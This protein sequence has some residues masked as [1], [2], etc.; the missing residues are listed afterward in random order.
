MNVKKHGIPGIGITGKT[1]ITGKNGPG[2][3]FG[4]LDSF[5]TF[6]GDT[7]LED[8][9]I[10]YEDIDYDITYVQNEERL[11]HIYKVGDLL[12]ITDDNK[13]ILYMVEVTEDLTTC[14]KEY[15][16]NHIKY[17]QPFTVKY[18]KDKNTIN[19]SVNIVHSK[20]NNL[21]L[22]NLFNL[23][24]IYTDAAIS[25]INASN[26]F[27]INKN[28]INLDNIGNSSSLTQNRHEF[29]QIPIVYDSS[30][31]FKKNEYIN[32]G[33]EINQYEYSN[34]EDVDS[35]VNNTLI[36]LN[37][38]DQEQLISF[39]IDTVKEKYISL[40]VSNNLTQE[41]ENNF[42]IDNLYI[43]N[44]NKGNLE[45]YYTLFN[46]ELI[47]DNDGNC[48]T[49][50]HL[51]YDDETETLLLDKKAFFNTKDV[52]LNDYH[53]GYIHMFWNYN[54]NNENNKLLN[55]DFY[56]PNYITGTITS[57]KPEILKNVI[58]ID[59]DGNY[60]RNWNAED[61]KYITSIPIRELLI[62]TTE[63]KTLMD[64]S[65]LLPDY[66]SNDDILRYQ[67]SKGIIEVE[68]K[69]TYPVYDFIKTLNGTVYKH[70]HDKE[71][72]DNLIFSNKL[73]SSKYYTINKSVNINDLRRG[74]CQ[75]VI[76]KTMSTE[77][78]RIIYTQKYYTFNMDFYVNIDG[79]V[80]YN[81]E[82]YDTCD[83]KWRI[84]TD[85]NKNKIYINDTQ[86]IE[87]VNNWIET[88]ESDTDSIYL[89]FTQDD[90]FKNVKIEAKIIDP[91][92]KEFILTWNLYV[93]NIQNDASTNSDDFKYEEFLNYVNLYIDTSFNSSIIYKNDPTDLKIPLYIK[94]K[95]DKP[96][97]HHDIV[98]WIQSSNGIKYY[99]KHTFANYNYQYNAYDII[100]DYDLD[101]SQ[102]LPGFTDVSISGD[103]KLFN[104][105]IQKQTGNKY[106]LIIDASTHGD[107]EYVKQIEIYQNASLIEGPV[108]LPANGIYTINN[109]VISDTNTSE[110]N[111]LGILNDLYLETQKSQNNE[112]ILFT[113]KYALLNETKCTHIVTYN[114]NIKQYNEFRTLPIINLYCYNNMENLEK[115]NNANNGILSNQFQYFID[116]KINDFN[117]N[118]WGNTEQYYPNPKLHLELKIDNI[119][120]EVI[121]DSDVIEGFKI[122]Y[123][124]IKPNI[125]IF[126]AT[127]KELEYENNLFDID[128]NNDIITCEFKIDDI[129]DDSYKLRILIETE[130]PIPV[131]IDSH[132]YVNNMKIITDQI[133]GNDNPA[134]FVLNHEYLVNDKNILYD[135]E[136]LK[137]VIA[138]ISM[139][140]G[141]KQNYPKLSHINYKKWF[142]N[143]DEIT[144]S[145]MPYLLNKAVERYSGYLNRKQSDNPLVNW[146]ALKFKLRYLQ[147]N[148]KSINVTPI[149]INHIKDL[150]PDRLYINEYLAKDND[151]IFDTYLELIYNS[152][153]LNPELLEDTEVFLYNNK[154]Y[155]A[156]EYGQFNNNTA[157]HVKQKIEHMLRSDNLLLSMQ[158]WNK[159]YE[160]N[161]YDSDN[162]Y[163]GHLETY[164]N[165]YQY[166]PN[167]IDTGQYLSD[168]LMLLK[169]IKTVNNSNFFDL[170]NN[171]EITANICKSKYYD[172]YTPYKLFR[173]LLYNMKWVYPYYQTDEYN[174]N[175][176]KQ[177]PLSKCVINENMFTFDS[178]PYNLAYSLY[179]RIM[180]NDE[181]QVNIVLMLRLPSVIREEQ[182]EMTLEDLN[183]INVDIIRELTDPIN[184]MN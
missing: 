41:T 182:Y 170:T 127:Q 68:D 120:R 24:K 31:I 152:E 171:S 95:Y 60:I 184:V 18:N 54:E 97:R 175:T 13:N 78:T 99:S 15:F 80:E 92:N 117:K 63:N 64:V 26:N 3:Y 65:D 149:N 58:K 163:Q 137:A 35:S 147:D 8:S 1:G 123:S 90:I 153:Y 57:D 23:N 71:H 131:Y 25:I 142:G 56:Q 135:S 42:Y 93:Y 12:Y 114:Y 44:T 40:N 73:D 94:D 27:N 49:L 11:N 102:I 140:A 91:N 32:N 176:I 129:Y 134:E 85:L 132:I 178:M 70:Y 33:K 75:P 46:P 148:V 139:I 69:M 48:F 89:K 6:I 62:N 151:D 179:P 19:Y 2:I 29:S 138:P 183:L 4:P 61:F 124:L 173:T 174:I 21:D 128:V 66:V 52:S 101:E 108:N 34:D 30:D 7:V 143:E 84:I 160:T 9:N 159:L 81:T 112:Y 156:S 86:T 38:L 121:N 88:Q 146:D 45:S 50:S 37:I 28:V 111:N 109:I 133:G 126:N 17:Y 14:T 55:V 100:T 177:L 76:K 164:G 67:N 119:I 118:N 106:K 165:G 181:E 116:I 53:F 150:L 130:N 36:N 162:A 74:E 172:D 107:Q 47:L 180:F 104:F 43:K 83:I 125:D 110:L 20:D 59:K 167:S 169:D 115:L 72:P 10:D 168:G 87:N 79:S 16:Q 82:Y 155:Y 166:L 22:T 5:F 39:N 141:Y 77:I 158:T 103:T 145:L 98:Q 157:V 105:D 96:Y 144:I 154:T 51:N 136:H 122:S 113:I 161:K